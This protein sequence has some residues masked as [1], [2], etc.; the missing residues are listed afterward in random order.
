MGKPIRNIFKTNTLTLT[1]CTDGYYLWDKIAG[2]NISIHAKSEQQAFIE[3]LEYYQ[4]SHFN[5]KKEYRELD[6]KVQSF[7]SQFEKED[8]EN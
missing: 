5:L 1:E 6:N 4:R 2:F 7:L 8:H 3:G